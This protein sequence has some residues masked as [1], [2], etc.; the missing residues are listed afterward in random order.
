MS[1]LLSYLQPQSPDVPLGRVYVRD[2]DDWDAPAKSYAWRSSARRHP[3]F[4]LNTST[5]ELTMRRGTTDG[6]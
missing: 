5:G 6:R 3:A 4:A 2:P 1:F